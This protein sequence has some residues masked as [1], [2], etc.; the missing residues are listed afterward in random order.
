MSE[1]TMISV[2]NKVERSLTKMEDS[3]MKKNQTTQVL[4]L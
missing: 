2:S 1:L 4:C 3:V